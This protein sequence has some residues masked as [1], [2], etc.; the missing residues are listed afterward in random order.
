[1]RFH[2][3]PWTYSPSGRRVPKQLWSK[4]GLMDLAQPDNFA[5]RFLNL[6]RDENCMAVLN[7]RYRDGVSGHDMLCDEVLPFAC[8]A[9]VQ[10]RT[11]NN[12]GYGARKRN[13]FPFPPYSYRRNNY[14][15]GH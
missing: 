10:R 14:Y 7:N 8:E 15:H 5:R 4:N 12:Y 6:D 13:P 11:P 1:M 3:S 9:S 2:C